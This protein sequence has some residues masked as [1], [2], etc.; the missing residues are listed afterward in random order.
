MTHQFAF[1]EGKHKGAIVLVMSLSVLL[2]LPASLGLG[3]VV[4]KIIIKEAFGKFNLIFLVF[5]Y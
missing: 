1:L 4:K 2:F 5:G 3:S